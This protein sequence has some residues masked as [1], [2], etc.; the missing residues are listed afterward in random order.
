MK[1]AAKSSQES[2]FVL[3]SDEMV[4]RVVIA[5]VGESSPYTPAGEKT[6]KTDWA[7]KGPQPVFVVANDTG[8]QEVAQ[9]LRREQGREIYVHLIE[10]PEVPIDAS[11]AKRSEIYT[12]IWES[13]KKSI[14]EVVKNR[15]ARTLVVDKASGLWELCRLARHGKLTQVMPHHY[16]PLNNEFEELIRHAFDRDNLVSV[17]IE[18]LKKEY[19]GGQGKN[20][21]QD[22][23][24]GKWERKGFGGTPYIVDINAAH[25]FYRREQEDGTYDQ[26]FGFRV[27][28]CRQNPDLVGMEFESTGNGDMGDLCTIQALLERVFPGTEGEWE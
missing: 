18:D 26:G 6:G 12:P 14:L 8:T 24:T 21:D 17:W 23:W 19:K 28:N 3:A 16:G 5:T 1:T 20:K 22:S 25:Y 9:K 15:D 7:L 4:K 13:A 10:T 11:A 2:S 27:N